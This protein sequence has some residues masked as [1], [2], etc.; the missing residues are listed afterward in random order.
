MGDEFDQYTPQTIG[1][2]LDK[3][4]SMMLGAP[5]FEDTTG[6]F[7][8]INI[9]TEFRALNDGLQNLRLKIGEDLFSQLKSL[10]DQMRVFFE[11]DADRKGDGTAKGRA[12]IV[13]MI[14]LLRSVPE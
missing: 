14:N 3:L 13:E 2:V 5:K 6:Y 8:K 11:A 4:G 7:P 12:I 10:S 9:S 1:E